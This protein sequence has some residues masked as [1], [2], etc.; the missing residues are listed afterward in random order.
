MNSYAGLLKMLRALFV[1]A[2]L[3]MGW[4]T[5][6]DAYTLIVSP[7]RYSVLQVGF[8]VLQRSPSV[9]VSYQGEG[10]TAEP[11]L[12]AWNGGEWVFVSMKDYREV[13]FLDRVPDQTI[14]IGNDEV[15]PSVLVEASSWSRDVVRVRDLNTS[16]LVNDIGNALKWK[17]SE[18]RWFAA[19]YN[20]KLQDEAEPRRKSSWYD[21]PGPLP[22][23]PHPLAKVTERAESHLTPVP[24]V[25]VAPS[26]EESVPS[27]PVIEAPAPMPE[28]AP[29]IEAP[30][31]EEAPAAA[32]EEQ[33]PKAKKSR[34]ARKAAVEEAI[35]VE[36]PEA[37]VLGDPDASP[38]P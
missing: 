27:V 37:S 18:W 3:T 15:L 16:A 36:A 10:S 20:L 7:A 33:A 28:P 29:A 35:D 14:L 5:R 1:G 12:H 24:V 11:V 22:N 38:N 13:N 9:L 32:V 31:V 30:A 2:V 6:A 23:R 4:G 21:Q 26:A 34:K 25:T 19:R 8:D 17:G